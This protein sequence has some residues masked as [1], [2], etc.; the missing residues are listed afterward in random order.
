M[1]LRSEYID[2]CLVGNIH[3]NSFY[4]DKSVNYI[5]QQNKKKVQRIKVLME[6]SFDVYFL[7]GDIFLKDDKKGQH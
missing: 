3:L 1:M 2:K 5:F 7:F 6:Y 4:N